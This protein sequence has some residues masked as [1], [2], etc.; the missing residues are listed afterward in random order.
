M[1]ESASSPKARG[2]AGWRAEGERS[3]LWVIKLMVALSLG[4]GR[5]LSRVV[6]HGIALYF[7]CFAPRARQASRVY[8]ARALGRPPRWR[9]VY[10]HVLCFASTIHDRVYWLR[11]EQGRF[12]VQIEGQEHVQAARGASGRGIVF[13]GAHMGS[14]EALRV[15][16]QDDDLR[17]RMLMYP[18]NANKLNAV[19]GAINPALLG[20]IIALGR[21]QALLQVRDALAEGVCVGVLADRQLADGGGTRL[22]FL[23]ADAPWPDGPWRMAAML[24][25][26]VV[27]MAGL[28]L[29][30][31]RYRVCFLPLAD[32][33]Q[34]ETAGREAALRAAQARYVH[35][36]EAL[37]REAPYNWFN[38][39]DIWRAS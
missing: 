16:S 37:C 32:F 34:L 25:A 11:G 22:P 7:V 15:L 1:S 5:R 21:P 29:G 20:S 19:L 23:G 26:P 38:F 24:K 8:L 14:F 27:F 13:V 28:Y 18:D 9:D 6:V 35:I 39:H 12:S 3:Y 31:N 17:V 10:A 4:L 30:D 2:A 33:S 36:L